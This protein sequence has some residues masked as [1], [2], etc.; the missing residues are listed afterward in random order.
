MAMPDHW[1]SIFGMAVYVTNYLLLGVVTSLIGHLSFDQPI[2]NVLV[3]GCA[4]SFAWIAGFF[5][6]GSPAG[7]GVREF[8]LVR[9]LAP[10]HCTG[11]ATGITTLLRVVTLSGD[12]LAC[13]V[14]AGL[15]K[16]AAAT[17]G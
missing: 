1:T 15:M 10:C 4:F 3:L 2:V 9:L 16:K 17:P 8:L 12:G 7:L 11:V 14:G 6:P 13:L 5:S